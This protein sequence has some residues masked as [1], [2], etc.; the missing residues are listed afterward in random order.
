VR[1]GRRSVGGPS[2]AYTDRRPCG[3]VDAGL[4][5]EARLLGERAVCIGGWAIIPQGDHLC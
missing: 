2:G 5:V 4:S 3:G 1:G